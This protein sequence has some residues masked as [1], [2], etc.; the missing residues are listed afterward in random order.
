MLTQVDISTAAGS[1]LSI[2][3]MGV[4]TGLIVQDIEGLDPVK[5][6]L[7]SSSFAAQDGEQFYSSRREARNINLTLGLEPDYVT[8]QVQDLRRRLYSYLMPKSKV[9]LTFFMNGT[10]NYQIEGVVESL[11][12]TIFAR[13]PAVVVSIMCY[14]PDFKDPD[15]EFLSGNSTNGFTEVPINYTGTVE[16]GMRFVVDLNQTLDQFTIY[17]RVPDGS[18]RVLTFAY[19]ML[20]GDAIVID[21]RPGLKEA[22][23]TRGASDSSV[24]YG[25]SPQSVWLQLEPGLNQIRV[26]VNKVTPV[27]WELSYNTRYGGL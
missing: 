13:E 22:T 2:P 27:P 5:A 9:T 16:T 7:V 15:F 26:Y 19:S 1:L 8:D 11:E 10:E 6:T 14:D 17:H 24:L 4:E 25:I 3:V 23:L 12:T 18:I 20:S 21:T